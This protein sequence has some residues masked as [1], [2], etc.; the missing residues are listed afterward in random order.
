MVVALMPLDVIT[1]VRRATTTV[2][3]HHPRRNS[4]FNDPKALIRPDQ[5][6]LHDLLKARTQPAM[7][8]PEAALTPS[9]RVAGKTTAAADEISALKN[10][11]PTFENNSQSFRSFEQIKVQSVWW[12]PLQNLGGMVGWGHLLRLEGSPPPWL[13]CLAASVALAKDQD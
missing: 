6:S 5:V 4:P 3:E 10:C 11:C 12:D 8:A 13:L 1:A 7:L 9:H 2:T